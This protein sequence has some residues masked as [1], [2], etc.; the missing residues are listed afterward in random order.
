MK[1]YAFKAGLCSI[2][3]FMGL[4]DFLIPKGGIVSYFARLAALSCF[5]ALLPVAAFYTRIIALTLCGV[6]LVTAV[7]TREMT[8][9]QLLI[10]FQELA[11]LVALMVAVNMLGI[12][13]ELGRYARLF[14]RFYA[15]AKQLYQPY[16]TS[17]LISYVL[18][19]L[20][21]LG[22]VAPSYYLIDNNLKKLE[23]DHT[24][25]MEQSG[26]LNWLAHLVEGATGVIGIF[27]LL[28]LVPPTIIILAFIGLHP[29]A[30]GIIIA[31]TL[32]LAPIS[33]NPF[34]FSVSLMSGMAMS[35]LISP[36]SI[37]VLMLAAY[38]DKTP[39]RVGLGWNISFV[40]VFIG[41][42]SIFIAIAMKVL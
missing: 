19:F 30:S 3:A 15:G 9:F 8:L 1:G 10:S 22:S 13:L 5:I 42:T 40:A 25:T 32:S 35:F 6:G 11:P 36:F 34:A 41:L 2:V 23:Y 12:P 31:K 20:S 27:G 18:S 16:I 33:L 26:G 24:S 28:S 37:L 7:Y 14:Q 17:L 21:V 29:F 4:F 38:T 39:H